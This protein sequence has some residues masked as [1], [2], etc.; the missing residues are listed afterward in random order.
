MTGVF[1]MFYMF[2]THSMRARVPVR[3]LNQNTSNVI[4]RV[5]AGETITITQNGEEVATLTPTGGP[6]GAPSYPF[7]TDAMG[8]LDNLPLIEFEPVSD[9]DMKDTLR[10]MGGDGLG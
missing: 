9:D 8:P 10:G 3:E 6:M 7:R 4:A 5:K 1:Y 2:Y